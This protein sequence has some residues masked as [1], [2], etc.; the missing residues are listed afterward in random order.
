MHNRLIIESFEKAL[1]E[2]EEFGNLNPSK[3]RLATILSDYI[4]ETQHFQFGERRLRDYYNQAIAGVQVEIKQPAVLNGLASFLGYDDYTDFVVR[5]KEN[6]KDLIT[7][8]LKKKL[9]A[10][11]ELRN[12]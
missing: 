8:N 4:E 11:L 10:I 12:F 7:L 6:K 1:R 3:S 5:L 9:L 2:E